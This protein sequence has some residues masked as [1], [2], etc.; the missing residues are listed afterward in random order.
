MTPAAQVCD[1]DMFNDIDPENR[2]NCENCTRNLSEM[3]GTVWHVFVFCRHISPT[4]NCPEIFKK[5]ITED[6]VC[7]TYNRLQVF[8]EKEEIED[9]YANANILYNEWTIEESFGNNTLYG[10]PRMATKMPLVGTLQVPKIMIN[11]VC[12]D[13]LK[14]FKVYLHLPNEVPQMSK[15]FYLVPH[16]HV[17]NL[18]INPRLILTSQELRYLSTDKRQCFFT[19]ERYLR[20]FKYYTQNNCEVECL[21]NLTIKNCGCQRFHMPSECFKVE[22]CS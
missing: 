8:R 2:T 16:Q 10:Y 14:G 19:D 21:A 11:H 7:F 9:A 15:Q 20:F 17:I 3:V 12:K 22:N 4:E 18:R 1:P 6:G 13:S 5:V